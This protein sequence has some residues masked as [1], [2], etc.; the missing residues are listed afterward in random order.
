VYDLQDHFEALIYILAEVKGTTRRD[1]RFLPTHQRPVENSQENVR[2]ESRGPTSAAADEESRIATASE[3][4]DLELLFRTLTTL[5]VRPLILSVPIDITF[6]KTKGVSRSGRQIYY[7]MTR[8][9]A[10]RYDF[11]LIQFE[12]HDGDLS[13]LIPHHEHPSP[14]G[15]MYYNKALDDFF[16]K[17][18]AILGE[19]SPVK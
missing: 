19:R 15:W 16:H 14:R 17:T 9:L 6:H 10:Q 2:I 8:Q 5:G 18:P 4:I 13:F 1:S 12:D 7:D 11:P 3:W